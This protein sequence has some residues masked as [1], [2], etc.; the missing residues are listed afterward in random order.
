MDTGYQNLLAKMIA[1][2]RQRMLLQ[3]GPTQRK[4]GFIGGQGIQDMSGYGATAPP[5][6]GG[7]GMGLGGV[8]S[9]LSDLG[10]MTGMWQPWNGPGGLAQ[11]SKS[12]ASIFGL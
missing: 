12:I 2:A 4:I 10:S 7:G 1:E 6:M 5:E 11:L 3:R 8:S 9:T